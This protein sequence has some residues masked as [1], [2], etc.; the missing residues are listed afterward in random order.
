[1]TPRSMALLGYMYLNDGRINNKQIVPY[2]WVKLSLTK[3][4]KNDSKEWGALKDYNYGFLWW[5][6]KMNGYNLFMAFGMG[7]QYIINFPELQLIVVTT[8][9]RDVLWD[10]NQEVP[11]LNMVSNYVLPAV[12][13]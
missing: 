2:D 11:I 5:L 3:T 13:K 10:N 7:G 8:A 6:G 1:M 12:N 9:N 4:R